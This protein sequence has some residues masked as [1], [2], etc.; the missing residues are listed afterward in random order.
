MQYDPACHSTIVFDEFDGSSLDYQT[1]MRLLNTNPFSVQTKN[2]FAAVTATT[3]IFTS[4][5][6]PLEVCAFFLLYVRAGC[7]CVR[8]TLR[9]FVCACAVRVCV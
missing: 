5:L 8:V 6:H 2:G 4:N 9:V 3:Y 7:A 1:L